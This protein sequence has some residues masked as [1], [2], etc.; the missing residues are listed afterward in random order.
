MASASS[1]VGG[2][3][4]AIRVIVPVA[5][6]SAGYVAY[7][8]NWS[9]AIQNFL[10]RPGRSS[11]ILLLL[12]V[13]LNWKNLPFAWTYRVFYAIVYH[14]MLRKS[15]DLTPRA[16]FK[17]II[18]ETRAPLLEIDYNLHKSNSTY[19]TDLDV[20]RT[21]LVSYLTRPAMR[22]LTDNARTGLVLDP[23]TGRPARG[24]MGIMLGSVSCSFKREIRA[25]RAYELWSRLLA[26]DRKWLYIVTHFLGDEAADLGHVDLAVDGEWDWARVEAQRRRGIE[27]AAHLAKLDECHGLF[28]GGTHGALAKVGPC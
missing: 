9:A 4:V 3:A 14:N 2:L 5:L 21:H 16:L 18:S 8:I 26:W 6:G 25:Y 23:K 22:S 11:R 27:L 19:F 17:P 7:K 20:A 28:D 1:K 13:V 24:P 10:T 12:F 15:P